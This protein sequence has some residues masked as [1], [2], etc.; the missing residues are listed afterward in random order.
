MP[1]ELPTC[2]VL[3]ASG[4]KDFH[5]VAYAHVTV[6][7][8]DQ[9]PPHVCNMCTRRLEKA[10]ADIKAFQELAQRSSALG[11]VNPLKRTRVT[12][13]EVG[14]GGGGGGGGYHPTQP[15]QGL[16]QSCSI[17]S[18]YIYNKSTHHNP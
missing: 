11:Q 17:V 18:G 9:L 13:G 7:E 2:L 14:G 6:D 4:L 10:T 1:R 15:E 12:C 8:D 3:K 5:T 16:A